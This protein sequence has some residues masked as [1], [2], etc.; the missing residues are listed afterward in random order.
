MQSLRYDDFEL[1]R[2]LSG[3]MTITE[4]HIVTSC[5][6]FNDFNPM[7]VD[8][9]VARASVLGK[10]ILPAPTTIGIMLGV[11]GNAVAG[12]GIGDLETTFRFRHPVGIG[13]TLSYTWEVV[14]RIDKPKYQGGILTFDGRCSNQDGDQVVEAM[15]KLLISNVVP[16][17]FL[18]A[19]STP[20]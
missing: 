6:L 1:G 3:R 19:S 17:V 15:N 7:H 14:E 2:V 8:E 16:D 9:E 13:D 12:T 20:R 11:I 10:R 4:T 5:G 18:S